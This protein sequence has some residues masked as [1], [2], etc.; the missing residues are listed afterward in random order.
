MRLCFWILGFGAA[1]CLANA[2]QAAFELDWDGSDGMWFSESPFSSGGHWNGQ[3]NVYELVGRENGHEGH[4]DSTGP[5]DFLIG[6]GSKVSYDAYTL[7]EEFRIMQGSNLT[8]TGGAVWEQKTLDA[9]EVHPQFGQLERWDETYST[10]LDP[11]N[12]NLDGGTFRR[13]GA[14]TSDPN[15]LG[16]G[17]MIFGSLLGDDNF[18]D[19]DG[20]ADTDGADFLDWQRSAPINLAGDLR[21]I[22]GT[23]GASPNVDRINI[24]LTNGGS[25]ENEGQLWFGSQQI[26][27][28]EINVNISGG[29]TIKAIGGHDVNP[30]LASKTIAAG[31]DA[32]IVIFD[33]DSGNV[34]L[35]IDFTGSGSITTDE[36][37]INLVSWNAGTPS[38]TA[39]SYEDLWNAGIL[40]ANGGSSGAFT[41][42][43]SVTGSPGDAVYTLTST[44]APA[45]NIGAVPEPTSLLLAGLAVLSMVAMSDLRWVL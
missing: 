12:L 19:R 25:L 6:G 8:I 11:S 5:A 41:D 15:D 35:T 31:A 45:P 34:N 14:T 9:D 23:Y 24:H 33:W 38:I 44:L 42:H 37:A 27:P 7:S 36:G 3:Q 16:S 26:F 18:G 10:L 21:K 29:S 30:G 39:M 40:T 17:A 20:D 28:M 32:S 2:S 22:V 4:R 43:F 13:I 1:V